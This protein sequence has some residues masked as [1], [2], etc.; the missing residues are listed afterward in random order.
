VASATY[1]TLLRRPGAAAFFL[2]S[3]AGRVGIAMTSLGAV[4][5]VQDAT[6]SWA[7]AGLVA[8]CLAVAGAVAAPQLAW[9]IDRRGQ[10]RVLPPILLAHAG[11]VA[12]LL[13]LAY[14]DAPVELLAAGGGLVGA[15]IP[16]LGALSAARWSAL[17]RATSPEALPT[18][19]A[20]ETQSNGAAY[21]IGPA[22]VSVAAVA[23]PA[24][25][26]ALAGTLVVAG[27][28]ALVAQRRT[29]PPV[30]A[31]HG[32]PGTAGRSL[33]GVG[34]IALAGVN[35]AV[36]AFFG[37]VP[38]AV[39]AFAT[40]RGTP[41]VAAVLFVVSESAGL[42]TGWLYG[43]RRWSASQPAHL[44]VAAAV[45]ALGGLP[46]LLATSPYHLG[47]AVALTGTAIAVILVLC[48]TRTESEVH[49]A[50]LT[51]AFTWLGSAGAAGSALSAVIAGRA[52]D[53]AGAHG[54]LA[55]AAVAAAG[56]GLFGG[57]AAYALRGR[58]RRER[59]GSIGSVALD[60]ASAAWLAALGA[61]GAEREAARDRL[62]ELL[63]RIARSEVN[64]RSGQLPVTG[65]ELDDIAYQAAADAMLAVLAKLPTFRGESRFT[66]WAY[67]FVM[68]E[69]STKIGRHFWRHPTAPMDAE[70]WDRLPGRFDFRP[71]QEAE[72]RDL[73]A[74]VRRAVERDLTA[75]QRRIFVALVVDGVPLDALVLE[76]GA[77]R[78]AVHKAL[79]DARR[80][81]RAA[82]VANGHLDEA[83]VSRS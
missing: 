63:L 37:A 65:A 50:T 79:F 74:A 19:F 53:T 77:N 3:S 69:V 27:G 15:S 58:A 30:T 75:Y 20:L 12:A 51:R 83:K 21:L 68:F 43:L 2:S 34:F 70:D 48:A 60:D 10:R 23:H 78:N 33:L 22:V 9:L 18:A 26:T 6:G 29:E 49:P 64:R 35:L 81:V 62:H 55:V 28:F 40:E 4:W 1:L 36:G 57:Y 7:T 61:T 80:K 71:E 76:L 73:L 38:I 54:G 13:V 11:A 39:T 66:T 41:G 16:Q 52:V 42:L 67:K 31:G 45:L 47:V 8:A 24:L 56:T 25:G 72:W 17:L 32:Q 14:A 82:L 59:L 5:L 46:M 44:P